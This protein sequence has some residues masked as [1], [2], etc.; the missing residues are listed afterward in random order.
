MSLSG[1]IKVLLPCCT[2]AM[3]VQPRAIESEE[4]TLGIT[5]C[6]SSFYPAQMKFFLGC[7]ELL[8]LKIGLFFNFPTKK[9]NGSVDPERVEKRGTKVSGI[10]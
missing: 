5:D 3:T 6:I 4:S 9:K 7:T 2:V 1:L 8:F 10:N